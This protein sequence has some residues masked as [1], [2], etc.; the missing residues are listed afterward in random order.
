MMR[1]GWPI[2]A[3]QPGYQPTPAG[4]DDRWTHW[5]TASRLTLERTAA[6]TMLRREFLHT[7]R[8]RKKRP[9]C[10]RCS[11]A[12]GPAAAA[13]D[14]PQ[15]AFGS[16]MQERKRLRCRSAGGDLRGL[17][18]SDVWTHKERITIRPMIAPGQPAKPA[19]AATPARAGRRRC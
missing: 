2:V 14:V 17:V 19:S 15:A 8:A 9:G 13:G 18:V 3:M 11:L 6:G 16:Q 1:V 10:C 4:D 5:C 7:A 12:G